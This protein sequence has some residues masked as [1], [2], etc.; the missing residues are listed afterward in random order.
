MCYLVA[1]KLLQ[2]T[3][4]L[5]DIFVDGGSDKPSIVTI[6]SHVLSKSH[7]PT[8]NFIERLHPRHV[9]FYMALEQHN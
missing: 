7:Y 3:V 2:I 5:E 6:Q 9:T 8:S 1:K 4:V